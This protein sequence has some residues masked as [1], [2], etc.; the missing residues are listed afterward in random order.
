MT[1]LPSAGRRQKRW[2]FA[3]R[4]GKTPSTRPTTNRGIVV[5]DSLERFRNAGM[6]LG[7]LVGPLGFV[8]ANTT[9]AWATRN[10]GDDLTGQ[11]ALALYAAHPL[12]VRIAL[13]AALI[14]SLFIVPGLLG[15]MR[16]LRTHAPRLSLAAGTLMIAGYISYFGINASTFT[17]LAFAE[18]GVTG[19]QAAAAFEA[20]QNDP[21]G[22]WISLLFVLGNII[23]TGLLAAALWRS[24]VVVR[25][26]ALAVLA[27]PV[28]HVTGLVAGTEWF[29]VAGAALQTAGL[30]VVAKVLWERTT[31]KRRS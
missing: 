26:A 11:H 12:A 3:G 8:V 30:V 25:W 20:G 9:Y 6:A 14:G 1:T 7:L 18:R 19:S 17:E 13:N 23:G 29:E 5:D 22:L 4:S 10:G 31:E 15:A 21:A 24:R 2:P 27:W 28:L 16:V